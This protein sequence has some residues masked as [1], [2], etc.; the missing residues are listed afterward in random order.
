[1]KKKNTKK[2]VVDTALIVVITLLVL[3]P[4]VFLTGVYPETSTV[5]F[6]A[7]EIVG[8]G[9]DF[10]SGKDN[11]KMSVTGAAVEEGEEVPDEEVPEEPPAEVP[12]EEPEEVK[13]PLTDTDDLPDDQG[14]A[15][16]IEEDEEEPKTIGEITCLPEDDEEC[17]VSAKKS[18]EIF[19]D[20]SDAGGESQNC[21]VI[22]TCKGIV[23]DEDGE[24][25][26]H[27]EDNDCD[28]DSKIPTS[29]K[30]GG[31][32]VI[33][34]EDDDAPD[35]N[36]CGHGVAAIG[37]VISIGASNSR[38]ISVGRRSGE[39]N[40]PKEILGKP[41]Y[42]PW[43]RKSE[44]LCGA[45]KRWYL[46]SKQASSTNNAVIYVG[47][48]GEEES[49]ENS[50][51]FCADAI[52][53]EG[54]V[55][56]QR[57]LTLSELLE[58]KDFDNDGVPSPWDCDD[59]DNTVYG[60][61]SD[62]GGPKPVPIC[63][64]GKENTCGVV[65][66]EGD[67]CDYDRKGCL[68]N[69]LTPG[70]VC[71]WIE[72]RDQENANSCCGDDTL[73]DIGTTVEAKHGLGNHLCLNENPELVSK[74]G[75]V[76]EYGWGTVQ[77]PCDEWCWVNAET[78]AAFNIYTIK[79][80]GEQAFDVVSNNNEWYDCQTDVPEGTQGISSSGAVINPE[81][82]ENANRFY[83]YQEGNR[84]SWADCRDPNEP[85][86][87][88]LNS[89]KERKPGDGLFAIPVQPEP[90]DSIFIEMRNLYQEFYSTN[91]VD[92]S[93]EE[94]LEFYVRFIN[95][96]AIPADVK[97]Y[98]F[99]PEQGDEFIPY[100]EQNVLGFA[101]NNPVIELNR[102]IHV[103]VQIPEMVDVRHIRIDTSNERNQ[104]EIKNMFLTS[105]NQPRICSG[106]Y[107]RRNDV[108]SWLNDLDSYDEG[109]RISGEK[110]CNVLYDPDYNEEE[111][112]GNAWLGD[113]EI[114]D[115]ERRC[116]GNTE[117]EYY[118]D[119]SDKQ[120]GC[121]NSEPILPG[122]TT[123]NVEFTVGYKQNNY[124][125]AYPEVEYSVLARGKFLRKSDASGNYCPRVTCDDLPSEGF[126]E[127]CKSDYNLGLF[128]NRCNGQEASEGEQC[129]VSYTL[130]LRELY[131]IT[132]NCNFG[133]NQFLSEVEE[134]SNGLDISEP[135]QLNQ[136]YFIKDL[137][138]K[139]IFTEETIEE[140]FSG[141]L[142]RN[143][144]PQR[145]EVVFEIN[146]SDLLNPLNQRPYQGIR[147]QHRGLFTD[148]YFLEPITGT[149][150][151]DEI[152][153]DQ[154]PFLQTKLYLIAETNENYEAE[155]ET[156]QLT[157][158]KQMTYSCN[159]E[160]CLFPVPGFP[161]YTITNEHEGLYEMYYVTRDEETLIKGTLNV[162]ADEPGNIKVKKIA[163]Q[164][165]FSYPDNE[166]TEEYEE[167]GFFGCQAASFIDPHLTDL[168]YCSIKAGHFCSYSVLHE[169]ERERFTTVNSWSTDPITQVGYADL[170]EVP[171][172]LED[173]QLELKDADIPPEERN[174]SA[175]VVPG[176]NFLSNAEFLTSGQQIPHWELFE[177]N[178]LVENE[179]GQVQRNEEEGNAV[180][181]ESSQTLRS[182]QVAV[183]Q[184]RD[185]QLTQE[186]SCSSKII[187]IDEE[188]N[189]HEEDAEFNTGEKA[190]LVVEFSGPCNLK[191]PMLQRIDDLGTA[192]Y[193]Y[194]REDFGD[195]NSRSG[196]ACC[197]Q[198]YCWSGYAC[199][200]PM[201]TITYASEHI[202]EGR[203]YRCVSGEWKYQPPKY[204]W[205]SDQWGFCSN[206]SQC[207]VLSTARGGSVEY[208]F[209]DFYEGNYP[210]CI[211]DKEYIFD[212]YCREGN[213]TSR[214]K[215]VA[216]KLLEVAEND[217]Y[218]LYCTDYK[219]AL[220]TLDGKEAL[221]GGELIQQSETETDL[222]ESLLP[223]QE[224]TFS[225][226]FT[227]IDDPEGR[228][229]IKDKENTCVN[230]V[231]VLR[232]KQS[233]RFKTA[234]AT[235][236]NKNITDPD[237]FLLA[238]DIPYQQLESLCQE[239]EG[240]VNC[241]IPV[242]GDLWF[243]SD[244]LS[245]IYSKEGISL[246]PSIVQRVIDFFL[247]LFRAESEL[248]DNQRFVNEAQ[249]FR[250]LYLL[251][252]QD[253]QVR[254]IKEL[255]GK[256]RT[257]IAEYQ[258]FTTPLCDYVV[259]DRLN[260]PQ[261][262]RVEPL[263]E[264]SGLKKMICTVE[265]NLQRIETIAGID[266]LWPQLTGKLRVGAE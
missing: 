247:G 17:E 5:V 78:S 114:T 63:G 37:E 212:N 20:S 76:K 231:C 107:S 22:Q 257:L 71:S 28:G 246:S 168:S 200:E 159:K 46:C 240:F 93:G 24:D 58:K 113:E 33:A 91:R 225:T 164:V 137:N 210:T 146:R 8:M 172:N 227:T 30:S 224:D 132:F 264:E 18:I 251:S 222:E 100:Y 52:L 243:S 171:E 118:G 160:E 133:P 260:V 234:F 144:S 134:V 115:S 15:P 261:D 169:D 99:G 175:A 12:E 119:I 149:R 96:E 216:S 254:A 77:T 248:A 147:I 73:E 127:V 214:T 70:G 123:M 213:W 29:T 62:Y 182:E 208:S 215:F 162:P 155:I 204:D 101:T 230:N 193:D 104:I 161:P 110:L 6:D 186:S 229:L 23:G 176:R 152:T 154:L 65:L 84:M 180:R 27:T 221:I 263:E 245:V 130:D 196:A 158:E 235:S 194:P 42:R 48:E 105:E 121:W 198:D 181:L 165:I 140:E 35:L 64:D 14:V 201:E 228:R 202:A 98:V 106:D 92:F 90:S 220:P 79:K 207:F 163:Q 252:K 156:E 19:C 80:P 190:F 249:N 183:P 31:C 226:C 16:A 150:F 185:M 55:V 153:A 166:E 157:K 9:F 120:V 223:S 39:N 187:T 206:E 117:S 219:E 109:G 13:Q 25:W 170:E 61:F 97:L 241:D 217:E 236:L 26:C 108:S 45:N 124:S 138:K 205:Q 131:S 258:G 139:Y 239:G 67:D 34:S 112:T 74:H 197:P 44:L 145:N 87:A 173:I 122:E 4:L 11:F 36:D 85:N 21:M 256:Q 179:R 218:V 32:L 262:L 195:F 51:F 40:N 69:C 167:P 191:Q 60:D 7:S 41:Y 3:I 136:I 151:Y 72:D 128:I 43:D 242:A 232:Y 56:K 88:S 148:V 189:L 244:L 125:I 83:C 203:D 259:Q 184:E 135:P 89:I 199:V 211:E 66:N 103:K 82:V 141:V 1:M 129:S 75:N 174:F 54:D 81:S 233:G 178:Q 209:K 10:A 142:T 95:L 59:S 38:S 188:G 255:Q 111:G 86:Q 126:K 192:E 265:G 47:E 143:E 250:E 57:W 237:S 2:E 266:F 102:W 116:C 177:N 49:Y 253:K 94:F 238:L 50:L 53:E 68:T